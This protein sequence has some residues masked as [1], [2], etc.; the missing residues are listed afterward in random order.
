[1]EEFFSEHLNE[2]KKLRHD[3]HKNPELGFKEDRTASKVK[4]FLSSLDLP[5]VTGLGITGIVATVE[6]R[7]SDNGRRVGLRADMD[8]L[9]M[10]EKS[11]HDHCSETEGCMHACGHDGHTTML[12]AVAKYLAA[13]RDFAG[14]IYLVFQP[15]E[16]GGGGGNEMVKNGLFEQF[17]MDAIFGLHNWPY[18]DAGKIA[19]LDGP[20]MSSVDI[21]GLEI[22]GVG[23]HGGATPH[24]T[25]DPIRIAG[26]LIPA[27]HSIISREIDPQEPAVLSLCSIQAGQLSAFNVIPDTAQLSGTVRTFSKDV[28]DKIQLAVKRICAGV[29]D[30]FGT[31]IIVDYQSIFPATVNNIEKAVFVR[32]VIKDVFPQGTLD[33]T[34]KPSMGGEDFSFML[35]ACP[36]AYVFLGSGKG[37][38]PEPLHSPYFDF[39]DDVIPI[40]AKLLASIGLKS[41]SQD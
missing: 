8:A 7:L 18:I 5:F 29:A 41:L 14:I 34:V 39:N 19:I 20:A 40:G 33:E 2:F 28:R 26:T 15:A 24:F 21:L 36:G 4:A 25:T 1:M 35:N 27:L 38:N 10:H 23:G 32:N 3:F 31:E 6:G 22:K 17:P 12:L 9:P 13:H 16:E 37:D 30:S 11:S